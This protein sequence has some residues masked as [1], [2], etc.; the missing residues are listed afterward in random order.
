MNRVTAVSACPLDCFGTCSLKVTAEDNTVISIEPNTENPVT[1][2]LI[3]SK[4]RS[5]TGRINHPDRILEPMRR[6]QGGWEAIS[7]DDAMDFLTDRILDCLNTAGHTSIAHFVG[8]GAAGKLKGVTDLFF[9]HLGGGTVFSGGLCWS[10]GIRAQK[11]DFGKVL[12]HSPEDLLN[13]RSLVLWGKNPADTHFHLLPW[14][15][16]ARKNGCRVILVDPFATASAEFSDHVIRPLPGTD[17]ALAALAIQVILADNKGS[18][19]EISHIHSKEPD[20]LT[21]IHSLDRSTLLAYCG[22][23]ND[24]LRILTDAYG[25]DTPCTTYMGYGMQRCDTGGTAVRLVDLLSYITGQI[26]IP[27]G[28]T[29]YANQVNS[30]LFDWSWAE[31]PAPVEEREFHQGS[32]GLDILQAQAPPVKMFFI[33]CANP[34]V[35]VTDTAQ[36]AK[37]LAAVETVVV[38]DH[39][40]TDTAAMADLVLPVTYFLEDEDIITSGM[41]NGIIH[42]APPVVSPRGQARSELR[43]FSELSRRLKLKDFPQLT[44]SQ[45]LKRI[46]RPLSEKGITLD[47]IKEKGWIS[48]PNQQDVPWKDHLFLTEDG[49]YNPISAKVFKTL[50][51]SLFRKTSADTLPF[52]SLHTR[53]AIN[54]QHTMMLSRA[55]PDVRIHPDTASL[56][57]I[58]TGDRLLLSSPSGE[59]EVMAVIDPS[60]RPGVLASRAG[61]WKYNN[62]CINDLLPAGVSDIG[63]QA[64]INGARV[65]LRK[66]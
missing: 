2:M 41:W 16:K 12:S 3:C 65:T 49:T 46:L 40:M 14:I 59:I 34:A 56:R 1:G 48:S 45:W 38:L 28:G 62:Q 37:A 52:I 21:H 33:A 42:Y 20:L 29:N 30:T 27:G 61:Y 57:D 58:C 53:N 13:A 11:L 8:G 22:I 54:S 64:L 25:S 60:V 19:M 35:Q 4:G 39:F 66:L 55:L 17:W 5:H 31:A 43:I 50:T 10:A 23:S 47:L 26:G 15:T 9:R 18:A 36:L 51:E 7:W 32:M 6:T 63:G 44:E 24:D